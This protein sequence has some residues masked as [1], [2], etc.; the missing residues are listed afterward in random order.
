MATTVQK[1]NT[2]RRR[3]QA[4]KTKK[5]GSDNFIKLGLA[6]LVIGLLAF[7]VF[8]FIGNRTAATNS[9]FVESSNLEALNIDDNYATVAEPAAEP[10]SATDRETR[11]LGPASDSA[12]VSLAQAGQRDTP[13]LVW[14]H[15]D[16]CHIC[17]RVK[18]EVINLGEQ[19]DGKVKI[20]RLNVD[21]AESRN[22]AQ[23]Y[24]VRATPTFVLFDSE[25]QVRGQVPGWPGYQAFTSA[26]DQLLAGS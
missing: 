1:K 7:G 3:G 11:F 6:L 17:Q 14:F 19:Y 23:Q 4:R 26:F 8:Q 2:K 25:G 20:V 10:I 13:T 24:G 15:A 21:H 18:P 12:T 5:A 9:A 22:A 16:W